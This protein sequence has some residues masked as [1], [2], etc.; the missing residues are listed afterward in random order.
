MSILDE[1]GIDEHYSPGAE[2]IQKIEAELRQQSNAEKVIRLCGVLSYVVAMFDSGARLYGLYVYTGDGTFRELVERHLECVPPRRAMMLSDEDL[3]LPTRSRKNGIAPP[4]RVV[5]SVDEYIRYLGQVSPLL[6]KCVEEWTRETVIELHLREGT[7]AALCE[8]DRVN[9]AM[10]PT[11]LTDFRF[12]M[13]R[14]G[15]IE[16]W[17]FADGLRQRIAIRAPLTPQEASESLQ[18]SV[19]HIYKLVRAKTLELTER[20]I[21]EY[22]RSHSKPANKRDQKSPK[23]KASKKRAAFLKKI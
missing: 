18:L 13:T 9:P 11:R 10:D 2:E 4:R 17:T 23:A 16:A 1:L 3:G 15:A 19:A 5:V 12:R 20:G 22:R 6:L 21:E 14:K 7:A 8:A